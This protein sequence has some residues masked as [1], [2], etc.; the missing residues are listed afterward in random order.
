[1]NDHAGILILTTASI[2]L[3]HTLIGPDHYIPFI[4]MSKTAGWSS[5]KTIRITLL[6]GFGHILGSIILGI[7]GIL[8]GKAIS[9]LEYIESIRSDI[10]GWMFISL[11]FIYFIWGLKT[12]LR[13]REHAH[14]HRHED[15]SIHTH[16]H[17][18]I[19]EHTHLHTTEGVNKL[20]PWIIFTIFVFGPCEPLIPIIIYPAVAQ[21]ILLTFLLILIFSFITI[22]TMLFI[23]LA[24]VKGLSFVS[25]KGVEKYSHALAGI[26]ILLCGAAIQF[27][28]L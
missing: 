9:G 25:F 6:S 24:G 22:G 19:T 7:T 17:S 8:F 4:A 3:L 11:G 1:M 16:K 14:L 27:S 20:T 26:A 15:G 18:H 13:K 21:N 10:A 5:Q 12:A 23:V 2:A 28:G